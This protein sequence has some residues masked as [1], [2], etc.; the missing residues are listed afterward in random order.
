[1]LLLR[2][3]RRRIVSPGALGGRKSAAYIRPMHSAEAGV[4]GAETV[5]PSSP[6]FDVDLVIKGTNLQL[7]GVDRV[8]LRVETTIPVHH[9]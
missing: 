1:M 8:E 6:G 2:R 7:V 3:Q 5:R 9:S 4:T